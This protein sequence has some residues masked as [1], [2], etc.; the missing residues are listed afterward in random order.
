MLFRSKKVKERIKELRK[1]LKM[2]QDTFAEKLSLTKNYISLVENGNRNLSEQSIK[3]LCSIFNV[4]EEWLR[5]GNGKMFIEK[6]K[7]EQISDMLDDILKGEETDFKY[8]LISA[9]SKLND[10]DWDSLEKIIRLLSN[11]NSD[12]FSYD[13]IP[14]A[15]EIEKMYPPVD[16]KGK[17]IG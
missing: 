14:T 3:V 10:N 4:N 15:A 7:D 13:E 6:S 2:S 17:N 5:T 1:T 8:R 12:V 16:I 9:L 11:N